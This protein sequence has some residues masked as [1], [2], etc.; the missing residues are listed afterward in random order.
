MLIRLWLWSFLPHLIGIQ[1][2]SKYE[3]SRD[4]VYQTGWRTVRLFNF[5][6]TLFTEY[7]T[8]KFLMFA[9]CHQGFHWEHQIT[10][11]ISQFTETQRAHYLEFMF[12]FICKSQI[13]LQTLDW[14]GYG[15]ILPR[16]LETVWKWCTFNMF[17]CFQI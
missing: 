10:S 12:P 3:L 9:D 11:D 7:N 1:A 16:L 15:C 14:S 13:R 4:K 8:S 17:L 2:W 5:I 6:Q